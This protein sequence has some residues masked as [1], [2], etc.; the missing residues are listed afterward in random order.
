MIFEFG[1]IKTQRKSLFALYIGLTSFYHTP[2]K[3]LADTTR[4]EELTQKIIS[5]RADVETLQDQV[6]ANKEQY[7]STIQSLNIQ[8]ADLAASI[9][10]EQMQIKEL[11]GNIDSLRKSLDEGFV[12]DEA[13]QATLLNAL[14]EL[15]SY[16]EVSLPF[17]KEERLTSLETLKSDIESKRINLYKAASHLWAFIE[18]EIRLHKDTGLYKQ[19]L[20][21]DGSDQLVEIAKIG[22]IAM[23][24]K[25]N[26]GVGIVSKK[27]DKWIPQALSEHSDTASVANL[28]ESLKKGIR[29][30]SFKLPGL[31]ALKVD[32]L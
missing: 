12:S 20:Q 3:A 5:M 8:K 2:S 29:V 17:K 28:F 11:S 7:R 10:R 13:L 30:G 15:T 25:R 9:Q 31:D 27:D 1:N 18:D 21:I 4:Y 19:V 32:S 6:E 16:I 24:Y 23:Y 26:D 22:M 14:E